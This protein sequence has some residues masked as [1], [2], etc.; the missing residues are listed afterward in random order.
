MV[1]AEAYNQ[2]QFSRD[3]S[4]TPNP[5]GQQLFAEDWTHFIVG[6]EGGWYSGKSFI[7]ARKLIT[8]HEYNAFDA[9]GD[10]TYVASLVVAPTYSNAMDFCV[11]HLQDACDEAGLSHQWR[12]TGYLSAGKYAAPAIIIPDFGTRDQPSVILIRSADVP[13]RITGFT[14][15]GAWGDEPARWKDDRF[16]PLNDPFLQLTG[17]VRAAK[18]RFL[19]IMLT[20][21]NEGDTTRVYEE[22]HNEMEDRALYRAPTI[23]N[24]VAKD[25]H[26]RQRKMLTKELAEQ[27]LDGGAASL[28]GG[29]VYGSF[30]YNANVDGRLVLK[31][32]V[33]LQVSM[34]FNIVPG[35]HIEVGQYFPGADVIT[36]VH[37]IHSPR[38]DVKRAA[39]DFI[40][41]VEQIKWEW[42]HPLEIFGD[43][44]GRNEWAGTGETCYT[45]F[46][47][48]MKEHN[49]PYRMRVPRG[50]PPVIDRI[51][52]SNCAMMD[53]MGRVHYKIHPRCKRLTHDYRHMQRDKF[54]EIDKVDRKLSHPS[55]ADGY[56]IW[57][58]RPLRI[59]ESEIGGRISVR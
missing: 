10:A 14:V 15:G 21:T 12:G 51:N 3:Y 31:R 22:M 35:M 7:G 6:L 2:L 59:E 5:G 28:S 30:S 8:L 26:D 55:D 41:L 57:F 29:K 37:E 9:V 4:T 49:I 47:Q 38:L 32:G 56:R 43:A 24:V 25:F 40:E 11:P 58:I 34:D 48:K 36:T 23:E 18:A 54:G 33:P 39:D 20:Y 27:Y 45:I 16:D 17:R 52:A 13:R 44:T 1:Q 50:N 19:Q 46:Q 42:D 53:I